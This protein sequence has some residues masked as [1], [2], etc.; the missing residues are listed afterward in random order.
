MHVLGNLAWHALTTEHKH[1]AIGGEL[2][3]RYPED[4]TP[5][6]AVKTVSPESLA[7]LASFTPSGLTLGLV[8]VDELESDGNWEIQRRGR[9]PQM[10][11]EQ[12]LPVPQIDAEIVRLGVDDV[13]D[14]FAL[15][16]I[17]RPGPF[18]QRTI[19]MGPFFGIR[20]KGKLIAMA[21]TRTCL[22]GYREI[23]AVATHPNYRGRGYG[24]ALVTHLVN[25]AHEQALISFLHVVSDNVNAIRLYEKLGFRH[26]SMTGIVSVRRL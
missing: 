4:V 3:R 19:E 9:A 6:A 22:T 13:P 8:C 26:R 14:M 21:G 25:L 11:C 23:T 7:E 20:D 17:A 18:L 15:V 16:E 1:F 24:T 5:F 10:I 2:A 12:P